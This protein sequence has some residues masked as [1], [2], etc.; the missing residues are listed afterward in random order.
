ME[1]KVSIVIPVYN[2]EKY[3]EEAL[4]SALDQTYSNLE[5]ISIIRPSKDN[6]MEI[7]ESFSDKIRIL[8]KP[9][10]KQF[11]AFN[12]GIKE[13][14][15]NWFKFMSSDDI[16]YPNAIEE[17]ISATKKYQD[18]KKI[19][20]HTNFDF[21]NSQ[22]KI[23]GDRIRPEDIKQEI[24]EQNI[25]LLDGF[26]VNP[27]TSL[28]HKEV[29]DK[30]GLF[31]EDF[32][33]VGDYE[34]CLRLCLLHDFR[35]HLITKKLL[36]YRKHKGS[37]SNNYLSLNQ[38][39]KVQKFILGQLDEEKLL[40]YE[41]ALKKYQNFTLETKLLRFAYRSILQYLPIPLFNKL[42]DGYKSFRRISDDVS[43]INMKKSNQNDHI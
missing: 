14:K 1:D 10:I 21:I 40:K 24:F 41:I 7:L 36:K 18:N 32:E 22:G 35:L 33:I 19:I 15:G 37:V 26:D 43:L 31:N 17:L 34:I 16:L 9:L 12:L 20:Y 6:S 39:N 27:N 5:I 42:H 25:H 30:Y 29:F 8:S 2:S 13:M 3:L 4:E 28:I 23:T 38:I 11:A